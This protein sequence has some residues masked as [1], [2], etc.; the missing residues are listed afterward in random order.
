MKQNVSQ[1]AI[2]RQVDALVAR[3]N[4]Q[5][6]LLEVGYSHIGIGTSSSIKRTQKSTGFLLVQPMNAILAPLRR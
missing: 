5:P 1:A 6:S 2:L 4:G 3:K